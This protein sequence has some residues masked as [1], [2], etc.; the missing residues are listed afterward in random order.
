MGAG[1]LET[2]EVLEEGEGETWEEL[3]LGE[4]DGEG[5]RLPPELQY[6]IGD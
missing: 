4:T 2:D 1:G 3:G 5:D 6:L